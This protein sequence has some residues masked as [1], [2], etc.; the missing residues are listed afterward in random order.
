MTVM[1][2][3]KKWYYSFQ[4]RWNE[5]RM[6]QII[7]LIQNLSEQDVLTLARESFQLEDD[8][9][10]SEIFEIIAFTH[11]NI[12]RLH[13]ELIDVKCFYPHVMFRNASTETREQ[14]IDLLLNG[15]LDS[16]QTHHLM[17][18]LAWIGDK[19]VI[20]LYHDWWQQA[21]IQIQGDTLTREDLSWKLKLAGWQLNTNG[22]RQNLVWE[23][24]YKA[25]SAPSAEVVSEEKCSCCNEP[26]IILFDFDLSLPSAEFLQFPGE[27][28]R[29]ATCFQCGF[30]EVFTI[31]DG[32][33]NVKWSDVNQNPET[34]KILLS[35]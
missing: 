19:R 24:H 23:E 16:T 32:F 27:R 35:R 21:P 15:E 8:M 31:V 1:H 12:P 11:P 18:T 17:C 5:E 30:D 13:Q 3:I 2:Q 9:L 20:K 6:Q 33:G 10:V 4:N 26:L 34:N 29:I 14:L 7:N 25:I 28:L 22:E